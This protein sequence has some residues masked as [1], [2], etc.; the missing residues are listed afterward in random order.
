MVKA[1]LEEHGAEVV[2]PAPF[3]ASLPTPG[4][5]GPASSTS[6]YLP[7]PTSTNASSS[8][9]V[10]RPSVVVVSPDCSDGQDTPKLSTATET[11]APERRHQLSKSSASQLALV[12]ELPLPSAP[13]I[14]NYQGL[15]C[16]FN[17]VIQVNNNPISLVVS[18]YDDGSS[19]SNG[20]T[21][22]QYRGY[23]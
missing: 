21:A 4:A 3:N 17:C 7:R 11:T 15:S 12:P 8:P 1:H 6:A 5:S 10:R 23:Y 16:Y 13:G 2:V 14:V 19:C 9:I 18:F 20:F 22:L